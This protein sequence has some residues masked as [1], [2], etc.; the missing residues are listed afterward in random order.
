MGGGTTKPRHLNGRF[1]L[2]AEFAFEH[3]DGL[4][5]AAIDFHPIFHEATGMQ[6]GAVIAPTKGF[7]N[8]VQ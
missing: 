2:G 6:D 5:D 4:A 8:G 3:A 1:V 7:A